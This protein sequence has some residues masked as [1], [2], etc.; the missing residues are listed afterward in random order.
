MPTGFQYSRNF[1]SGGVAGVW[2]TK[3]TDRPSLRSNSD[4]PASFS[5]MAKHLR[6]L[7][8]RTD[9]RRLESSFVAFD[10]TFSTF[11]LQSA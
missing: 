2:Y 7:K 11:R 3:C 8:K 6:S 9:C 10:M 1:A 5:N 4:M